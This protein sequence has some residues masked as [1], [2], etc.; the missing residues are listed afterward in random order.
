MIFED[1]RRDWASCQYGE[2]QREREILDHFDQFLLFCRK[3][4]YFVVYFFQ[5]L[6]MW[7][8][9]R[10]GVG[11]GRVPL[12]TTFTLKFSLFHIR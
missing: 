4:M 1:F 10:H 6:I 9:K 3:F 11:M 2:V 5:A 7:R 12:K 8:C